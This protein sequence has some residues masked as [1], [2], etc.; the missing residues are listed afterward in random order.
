MKKLFLV[1]SILLLLCG[2]C[3]VNDVP[4]ERYGITGYIYDESGNPL[5]GVKIYCLYI[6]STITSG[7][8]SN[9][10]QSDSDSIFIYQLY[11]NFPNP[12]SEDTYV[13]FSLRKDSY[14]QITIRYKPDNKLV[15]SYSDTL[16]YGLFQHYIGSLFDNLQVRNGIYKYYLKAISIIDTFYEEKELL[17]ASIENQPN[18]I[19]D[20][21][22]NYFFNASEGFPGDTV[23][24]T[25]SDN[26]DII[27]T[28]LITNEL[29]FY[30][31]KEGYLSQVMSISVYP[32]LLINQNIMLKKETR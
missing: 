26:P 27:S 6:D 19:S 22:G 20:H 32:N 2:G 21:Q 10:I 14:I 11:Q 25:S 12:V 31:I 30:F 15:Y 4:H 1:L 17:L 9:S 28:K 8:K 23:V 16:G 29:Y 18:S 3:N 7:S 13:R 24:I 5:E